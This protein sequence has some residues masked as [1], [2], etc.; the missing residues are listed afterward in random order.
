LQDKAKDADKVKAQ[1]MFSSI[2]EAYD[3]LSDPEKRAAYDEGGQN[4]FGPGG[5]GGGGP[6]GGGGFGGMNFGG[7][8]GMSQEDADRIF[9]QFFGGGGAGGFN[10][11]GGGAGMRRGQSVPGFGGFGGGGGG[12]GGGGFGG[13]EDDDEDGYGGQYHAQAGVPRQGPPIEAPL[14]LTLEELY[15]GVVK[16]LKITRKVMNADGRS[17]RSEAKILEVPVKCGWKAGTK[18]T[19]EKHG[20]ESPGMIPADVVFV[21]EEKP[22]AVFTR[23]GNNLVHK[24]RVTL[25]DALCG[26]EYT[27][28]TLDE[29]RLRIPFG[30]PVQSGSTQIVPGEGFP[31]SK[32][33]G[34]QK[35]DLLLKFEVVFPDRLSEDQKQK[36]RNIL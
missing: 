25:K 19:F 11:G 26:G 27:L 14:R 35:G 10:F 2:S 29:R 23:E 32:T 36:L 5:G 22:H 4:P 33:G 6:G 13:Y 21:V 20:D 31:I 28:K 16:K 15:S 17:M 3:T 12:F 1:A 8:G 34:R 18:V 24:A 9:R 7:G 30:G